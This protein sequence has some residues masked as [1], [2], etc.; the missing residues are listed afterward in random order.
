M[1]WYIYIYFLILIVFC[2]LN[3]DSCLFG[4]NILFLNVGEKGKGINGKFL[5]YKKILFYRIILGFMIQGGDIVYGDGK[6]GEF[7]YG[8]IFLDENFIIKYLFVGYCLMD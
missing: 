4:R 7:V 6:G 3:F 1:Y 8:G 2:F 5:Y